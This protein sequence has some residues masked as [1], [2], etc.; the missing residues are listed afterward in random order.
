MG[1]N[2]LLNMKVSSEVE[3]SGGDRINNNKT[4]NEDVA[5]L[6]LTDELKCHLKAI[7]QETNDV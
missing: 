6:D 5:T 3:L 1:T 4:V 7:E 2:V